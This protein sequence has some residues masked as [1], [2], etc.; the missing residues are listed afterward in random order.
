[1]IEYVDTLTWLQ[2]L[3]ALDLLTK[4]HGRS[5]RQ[6]KARLFGED[7]V[8]EGYRIEQRGE[9]ELWDPK[10]VL[11][12][13]EFVHKYDDG[14]GITHHVCSQRAPFQSRRDYAPGELVR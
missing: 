12:K 9:S 11:S 1:M 4:R 5:Q 13:G 3:V 6:N 8:P 2:L 7:F 10:K 14:R